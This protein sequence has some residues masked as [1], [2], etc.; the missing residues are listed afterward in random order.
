VQ[1][2]DLSNNDYQSSEI[3][4][5]HDGVEAYLTEYAIVYTDGS[6]ASFNGDINGGNV[7]L[8]ATPTNNTNEIKVIRTNLIA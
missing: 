2:H 3:L 6:L 4:L 8:L 7:R 1:V 5:I